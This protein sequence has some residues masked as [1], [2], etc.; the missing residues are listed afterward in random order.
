M[1]TDD[2]EPCNCLR[3][4]LIRAFNGWMDAQPDDTVDQEEVTKKLVSFLG[5]ILNTMPLYAH[6]HPMKVE[7]IA[8]KLDEGA[9][10]EKLN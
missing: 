2:A 8:R 1:S 9:H 10:E 7:V 3:C 5:H 6:L 4:T